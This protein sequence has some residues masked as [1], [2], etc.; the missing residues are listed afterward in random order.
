MPK[1]LL[2]GKVVVDKTAKISNEKA[3]LLSKHKLKFEDLV[4]SR[5][6]DVTCAAIITRNEVDYI[7]GTGC[8]RVRPDINYVFPLFLNT[9]IQNETVKDWLKSNSV[10]QTMPNMNSTILSNLPLLLP[11]LPEQRKIAE[12]LGAW[13]EAISTLE[14]LIT[15]KRQLKQG[16][17]QQ[18]LT[19]KKRFKEFEGSE[20]K[21]YQLSDIA[22]ITMGT[23][24]KSESYNKKKEGLPL[25]QG[26]A[27]IVNRFSAPRIW[28]TEITKQCYPT[29]I[30]ISVRAPVGTIAIS[31]HHA[32][33]GRGLA[34]I[35]S[36]KNKSL[37]SY[38]YQL[39]L[40]CEGRWSKLSQGSTFDSINSSDIK[41]CMFLIP[42]LIAEQEK[43]ASVLWA[44]DTEISTLEKQLAAYKQQ[45]RGLMQQ[46]LTGK[47]RVNV[48]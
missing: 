39:L 47:I 48:N 3:N 46:L 8:L 23:S 14:K 13:D 4:F 21:Q 12:I 7:C 5:R 41:S 30:L 18:L 19:G 26:N 10:G 45:K 16:L 34:S 40:F 44:A 38:L 24:P 32:C 1:D 31:L 6:G 28:T 9:L 15:A 17:M 36:Q 33:I 42:L 43:I 35:Q 25:L 2:N 20:W 37:S 27:D 22:D 11:P 29:D